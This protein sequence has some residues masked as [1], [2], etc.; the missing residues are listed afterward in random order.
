MCRPVAVA[1]ATP[2]LPSPLQGEEKTETEA[3]LPLSGRGVGGR[4]ASRMLLPVSCAACT[5][6][7][8]SCEA[9]TLRV[10]GQSPG[11]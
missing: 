9:Y 7:R 5:C 4:V 11:G 6:P 8:E 3:P 10:M 1:N 2:T